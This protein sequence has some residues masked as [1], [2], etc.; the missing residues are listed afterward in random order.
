MSIQTHSI[1]SKQHAVTSS[2]EPTSEYL[3]NYT[4]ASKYNINNF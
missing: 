4:I 2:D 3:L 1:Q